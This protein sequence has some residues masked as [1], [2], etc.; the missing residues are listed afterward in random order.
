MQVISNQRKRS[1]VSQIL[2]TITQLE[3]DV[4]KSRIPDS[5]PSDG[6]DNAESRYQCVRLIKPHRPFT[7]CALNGFKRAVISPKV[8][9][10]AAFRSLVDQ[11]RPRADLSFS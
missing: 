8:D 4:A 5:R 2:V 11:F 1:L 9:F 7:A 6:I 3:I 10:L